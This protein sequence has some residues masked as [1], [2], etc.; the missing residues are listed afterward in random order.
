MSS[1]LPSRRCF[2][3]LL[4]LLSVE[5]L[6][7]TLVVS[8]ER[9]SDAGG[10]NFATIPDPSSTDAL[11]GVGAIFR[12]GTLHVASG[13]EGMLTNGTLQPNN[14]SPGQSFFFS[15]SGGGG[16][17]NN[18]RVL[19]DLSSPRS[20]TQINTYSWHSGARAP[21]TF[22][23][24]GALGNEGGFDSTP[25]VADGSPTSLGYS[26]IADIDTFH[27]GNGGQHGSSVADSLGGSIGTY[28]YLLFD[29]VPPDPFAPEPAGT[30]TFYGE[31]DVIAV[32]EPGGAALV[33]VGILGALLR[34]KA[35]V[36]K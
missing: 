15:D 24:Y 19:F 4:L 25:A 33:V 27:L 31:M 13:S 11:N 23:I 35:R 34:R 14:D 21:Q 10:F 36:G 18:G 1:P 7:A 28:R 6:S 12:D 5:P 29:I 17:V 20:I 22:S 16:T 32:P 8:D 9:L 26:L 3:P 30:N 2:V